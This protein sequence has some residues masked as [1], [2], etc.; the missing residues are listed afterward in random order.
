[1]LPNARQKK[2]YKM[3]SKEIVTKKQEKK[4]LQKLPEEKWYKKGENKND[5]KTGNKKC[6]KKSG[7]EIDTKP[8][9]SIPQDQTDSL[10]LTYKNHNQTV[11]ETGEIG[12]HT[13]DVRLWGKP[14]IYYYASP[15]KCR[16]FIPLTDLKP[17][18]C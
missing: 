14:G 17:C 5:T 11:V 2:C 9:I 3:L 12:K 6:Y 13:A 10:K 4:M 16:D 15:E 7:D 1:M 18:Y 8:A